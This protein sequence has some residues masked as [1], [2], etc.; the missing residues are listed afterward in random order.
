MQWG[1]AAR[2]RGRGS[3]RVTQRRSPPGD[4]PTG[5]ALRLAR[6]PDDQHPA[7]GRDAGREAR[8]PLRRGPEVAHRTVRAAAV[9]RD[10][11]LDPPRALPGHHHGSARAG[12]G[13][14]RGGGKRSRARRRRAGPVAAA[15]SAA[16]RR[17]RPA[18]R[19]RRRRPVG[20]GCC[21]RRG[22]GAWSPMRSPRSRRGTRRPARP[23][24][25]PPAAR[26]PGVR[27]R[28]WCP[29]TTRVPV[30]RRGSPSRARASGAEGG[31]AAETAADPGRSRRAATDRQQP[32]THAVAPSDRQRGVTRRRR[33]TRHCR[34]G[35]STR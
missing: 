1:P 32:R 35:S 3:R 2:A 34:G 5:G 21:R 29:A 33:R 30:H 24:T 6:A 16:E 18:T 19:A 20:A 27:R 22:E 23:P 26:R 13:R 15:R 14:E 17:T 28:S 12:G 8:E 11:R 31:N 4:Q 7:A 25:A 9:T 10:A